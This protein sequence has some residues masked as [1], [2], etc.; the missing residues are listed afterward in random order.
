MDNWKKGD[1]NFNIDYATWIF[2]DDVKLRG[3]AT[4]DNIAVGG[5]YATVYA[6][7]GNDKISLW[8]GSYNAV[9]YGEA[10]N[11]FIG[12][13]YTA[14]PTIYGGK[15]NDS[16]RIDVSEVYADGG[17]DNDKFILAGN[18]TDL[19]LE[20]GDGDDTFWFIESTQASISGGTGKNTYYFDPYWMGG[21]YRNELVITDFTNDDVIRYNYS[22]TDGSELVWHKDSSTGYIVL[23]DEDYGNFSLL[24]EGV[25]DISEIAGVTYSSQKK[26]ST[27]GEIFGIPG[28]GKVSLNSAGTTAKITE[29]F[30]ESSFK[31]DDYGK[32]IKIIDASE[33]SQDLSITANGLANKIIGSDNDD[34]IIGGKGNDTLTGGDGA[35]IFVYSSGDGNDVITDYSED[36]KIRIASGSI[37]KVE[38]KGT[39]VIFT[40]GKGKI[41]V[42]G[43]K[44]QI[45]TLIDSKGVE[46]TYP[47]ETEEPV[48]L[49]AA[50][51]AINLLEGY[52]EDTF[53]A[54]DYGT[55]IKII[56]ASEAPN[57]LEILGNKLANKITGTFDDDTIE[58]GKG[59]DTLT[60]GDGADIFVYSS[61]DGNDIIADY[62]EDD[63]DKIQ[64]ASGSISKTEV[65][66]S[67]VI[68]TVGKGK[69]SVKGGA[70]QIITLINEDGD[71]FTYPGESDEEPVSLNSAKT[72]ISILGGYDGDSFD[73][74][75]Y[76]AK[77][78]IIDASQAPSGLEIVG[79]KL[80]NKITGTDEDDTLTGGKGNDSLWGGGGDDTF[81]YGKGDGK[82]VIVG[83]ED[84]DLLEITGTFS[85]TYNKS[86][87]EV[88]FKVGSTANAIT[89][90]NFTATTFNINGDSY[91]I[92]G[93]KLVKT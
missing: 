46:S 81:I 41:S 54:A 15:G 5:S 26:T 33:V 35:D 67:T 28:G 20:G 24:L 45:I 83:F 10:G 7:G 71:E 22:G 60:G 53:D 47:S 25:T 62:S 42:K 40:V 84:D 17:A 79:N 32:K 92:S 29:S 36:D 1:I 77:I 39:T 16:I 58:G 69:I 19:T 6:G 50:K 57:A 93:T 82:D 88:Y 52:D 86:K 49:N 4:A 76:G 65:K 30:T 2:D 66:G 72:A 68:F 80:A 18:T 74:A 3:K 23:E 91:S 44:D 89:L 31:A 78:K 55:K 59:N 43:G 38:E 64:I 61:G 70:D 27:L 73:V 14:N 75:D 56:D 37:S 9:V 63:E 90:K 12:T 13:R 51:T 48:S 87:K 8:S 21:P 85:G 11:D 34:T